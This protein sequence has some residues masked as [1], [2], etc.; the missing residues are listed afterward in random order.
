MPS[1]VHDVFRALGDPTRMAIVERLAG[2]EARVTDIAEPF[3]MSLN[4]VSKHLKVLEESGVVARRVNGRV[5]TIRL[6]E[7]A[8]GAARVWM[9]RQEEFWRERL[10]NLRTFVSQDESGPTA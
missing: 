2:G 3:P 9:R 1:Q 4:A 8:F 10:E 7:E 5:H 6:N